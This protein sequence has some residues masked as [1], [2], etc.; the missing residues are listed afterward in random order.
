[1]A[2]AYCVGMPIWKLKEFSGSYFRFIAI[3]NR[4][5]FPESQDGVRMNVDDFT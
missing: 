4:R 2:A 3:T 5:S 1:M